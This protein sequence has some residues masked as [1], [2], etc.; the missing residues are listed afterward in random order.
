MPLHEEHVPIEGRDAAEMIGQMPHIAHD[1]EK[2]SGKPDSGSDYASNEK[3]DQLMSKSSGTGV[4][5]EEVE[6]DEKLYDE[7]GR[8]KVLQTADDF[9]RALV[10][11][12]DDP[13]LPIHTFR[14]WFTGVGLAVFGAVL[15]MLFVSSSLVMI[16]KRMLIAMFIAIPAAGSHSVRAF[17]SASRI[18]AGI[19]LC[20][21][22]SRSW[23]SFP[24][25]QPILELLESRAFQ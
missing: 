16:W 6:V 13:T 20:V 10:S 12:D 5:T 9:A 11:V 25:R 4:D 3:I 19:L 15:G 7:N 14:M 17:P 8:E 23:Q 2:T 22:H 18:Y 1:V 24:H 21:H